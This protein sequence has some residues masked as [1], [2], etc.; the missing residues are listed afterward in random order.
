MCDT[1]C[2]T[3]PVRPRPHTLAPNF[4]QVSR[5]L[6]DVTFLINVLKFRFFSTIN[7]SEIYVH[8]RN[9]SYLFSHVKSY[10]IK[11]KTK[12]QIT[13]RIQIRTYTK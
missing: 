1:S 4:Q 5:Q 2:A 10:N 8:H 9:Q 6:M 3:Y 13:Q 12:Q 11:N 7:Q